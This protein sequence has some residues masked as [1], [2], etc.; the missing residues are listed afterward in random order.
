[1]SDIIL[2]GYKD[3]YS[4]KK[5]LINTQY[6]QFWPYSKCQSLFL[7]KKSSMIK[8]FFNTGLNRFLRTFNMLMSTW[9]SE[10]VLACGGPQIYLTSAIIN[11]Y[12]SAVLQNGLEKFVPEEFR[13]GRED[14]YKRIRNSLYNNNTVFRVKNK[15]K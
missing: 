3:S 7:E 8:N 11:K 12:L 2:W 10:R 14:L 9:D 15:I 6:G 4:L 13:E 5:C 1:M